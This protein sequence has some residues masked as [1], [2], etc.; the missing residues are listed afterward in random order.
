MQ[1]KTNVYKKQVDAETSKR[2]NR[3]LFEKISVRNKKVRTVNLSAPVAI[4]LGT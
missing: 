3:H 4:K 1:L 2:N